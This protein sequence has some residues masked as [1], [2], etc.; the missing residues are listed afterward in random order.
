M[1]ARDDYLQPLLNSSLLPELQ[2]E[3]HAL[4]DKANQYE[5]TSSLRVGGES[6]VTAESEI[7]RL[8]RKAVELYRDGDAATACAQLNLILD[9]A[10]SDP[11]SG[12]LVVF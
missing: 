9:V 7:Q 11:R 6:S 4:I 5:F 12:Y 8:I 2:V 10:K 1:R 3:I